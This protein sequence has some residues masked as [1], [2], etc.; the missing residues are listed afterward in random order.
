MLV[1]Q[2]AQPLA[3]LRELVQN[4]LD[5]GSNTVEVK[6]T[7]AEED[8]LACL[9]VADSGEG[10]DREII[11][12]GLTRLFASSKENDLTKI[13][14]F[15]IGFVSVFALQ[16]QAVV[17]DTGRNGEFW[18][19]VFHP[20]RSFDRIRRDQ[21]CEGTSVSVYHRIAAK[22]FPALLSDCRETLEY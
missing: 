11:D 2:F 1:R 19:L 4:S 14:K 16:P 5:A 22:K 6:V 10:M 20:D 3:F 13:G 21:P 17:V 7:Y 15:G 9:Q 8:G 12:K 18:R